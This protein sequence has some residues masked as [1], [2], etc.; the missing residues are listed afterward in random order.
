MSAVEETGA[1][2]LVKSEKVSQ[3]KKVRLVWVVAVVAI[4]ATIVHFVLDYSGYKKG[5]EFGL[6]SA[7]V[8]TEMGGSSWVN[9]NDSYA[10]Q[11]KDVYYQLNRTTY[12]MTINGVK[13][14]A[15]DV[16]KSEVALRSAFA[17]VMESAGYDRY[18]SYNIANWFKYTNFAEYY[19]GYY[20]NQLIPMISYLIFIFAIV[21][22]LLVNKEA[23]KE[24]VVYEDSVLC[25][26]NPKK[27]KQL[28][29]EDINNVDFGKNAL[30][31]V[32]TGVKYKISNLTNAEEIKSVIIDKKKTAQKDMNKTVTSVPASSADELK[33][34]KDLLDSGVISQ[35]EF[36]AKKKQILGI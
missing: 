14:D 16:R 5:Q 27:S 24:L 2:V 3:K 6:A 23:K 19:S 25:K 10:E 26:I 13:I 8:A 36:D 28:V 9:K 33:K 30:K 21:Y 12:D 29:F 11:C 17:E 22:T 32:G 1:V 20:W 34:Y 31:L 35:D 18:S 15:S 7:I 4:V